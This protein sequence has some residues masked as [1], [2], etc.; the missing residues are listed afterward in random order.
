MSEDRSPTVCEMGVVFF[1]PNLGSS[2]ASTTYKAFVNP[3]NVAREAILTTEIIRKPLGFR[4]CASDP[5]GGAYT[6]PRALTD[7]KGLVAPPCN[8][9]PAFG[10][11][12]LAVHSLGPQN[13]V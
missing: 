8:S 7:W 11:S 10:L 1:C 13:G 12:D 4:G 2:S 5:F 3:N 6:A 9:T